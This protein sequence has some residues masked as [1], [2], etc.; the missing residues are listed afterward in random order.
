MNH[1]ARLEVL[2]YVR[3]HNHIVVYLAGEQV[4]VRSKSLEGFTIGT[5]LQNSHRLLLTR[6]IL[7]SCGILPQTLKSS[8]GLTVKI[9]LLDMSRLFHIHLVLIQNHSDFS[10]AGSHP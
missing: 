8:A 6:P 4:P 9:Y 10:R 3:D 1:C 7:R 5:A 2:G